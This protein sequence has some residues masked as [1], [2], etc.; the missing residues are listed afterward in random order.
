MWGKIAI[1]GGEK[2]EPTP[3]PSKANLGEESSFYFDKEQQRWING[4]EGADTTAAPAPLAPPPMGSRTATP[5]VP[6]PVAPAATVGP[7]ASRAGG[8]P[9][10]GGPAGAGLP[11]GPPRPAGATGTAARRGAR[12][13]Y[14]DVLNT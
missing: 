8:P 1:F 6:S 12:S 4:K 14:V 9:S 11:P 10:S 5:A 2:R 3:K 13:R 7:P